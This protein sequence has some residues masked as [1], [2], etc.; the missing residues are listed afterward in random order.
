MMKT[1]N[2]NQILTDNKSIEIGRNY[3]YFEE[4]PNAIACVEAIEDNSDDEFIK[5][6]LKIVKSLHPSMNGKEGEIFECSAKQGLY[7]YD[8]MWLIKNF[9]MINIFPS[10]SAPKDESLVMEMSR[11][12]EVCKIGAGGGKCCRY[13]V[14]G[15][16]GFECASLDPS[17]KLQID[18]RAD[19]GQMNAIS[20]NCDGFGI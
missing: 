15:S 2:H 10:M 5:L 4:F 11:V 17:M 3:S 6:K 16:K 20:I 18:Q 1:Y 8:G 12:K 13:L 7:S 19:S 9:N 14:M